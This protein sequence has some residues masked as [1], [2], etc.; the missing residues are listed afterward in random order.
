MVIVAVAR[1]YSQVAIVFS[2]TLL[3]VG[4]SPFLRVSFFTLESLACLGSSDC[5]QVL[6]WFPNSLP[7]ESISDIGFEWQGCM[8]ILAPFFFFFNHLTL[9]TLR[10]FHF[11]KFSFKC[12]VQDRIHY[13]SQDLTNK[14]SNIYFILESA[15]LLIQS[16]S[17][18]SFVNNWL[19]VG[20]F[21]TK[22]F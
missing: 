2:W 7:Q 19:I 4:T 9:C 6:P 13:L 22:N 10:V 21:L 12:A 20:Y 1:T 5:W 3:Q 16:K 11:V 8:F 14:E 15:F 18:C 17:Q